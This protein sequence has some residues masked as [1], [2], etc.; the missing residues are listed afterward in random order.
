MDIGDGANA[1]A[2]NLTSSY[3]DGSMPRRGSL[4]DL[5]L[6]YCAGGRTDRFSE[7][8]RDAQLPPR[9]PHRA[10]SAAIAAIPAVSLRRIR[11]PSPSGR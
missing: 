8:N 1:L 11:G 2:R 6:S 10:W 5:G 9:S 3:C 7:A 4:S